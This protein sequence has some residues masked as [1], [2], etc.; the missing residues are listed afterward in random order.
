MK[1][2]VLFI[3]AILVISVFSGI[4]CCAAAPDSSYQLT[5]SDEFNGTELNMDLWHH[6]L[7]T[8][9]GGKNIAE[10]VRVSNGKL[11]LDYTKT[12]GI[13]S[14][15][16]IITNDFLPYGYYETKAKFFNGVKGLHTSFWTAGGALEID[17]FES[18]TSTSTGTPT[19]YYNLHYWW[20]EHINHGGGSYSVE[21]DG[22]SKTSDWFTMGFEWLPGKIN[23]YANGKFV[24][25]YSPDVYTPS[26]LWLT[27]VATPEWC[28]YKIDDSKMDANGYFGSS[29]YEYFRYYAKKLKGVNLLGNG[30]FELSRENP[31]AMVRY[32]GIS[33][34]A[35]CAK[36]PYAYDGYCYAHLRSGTSLGEVFKYLPSAKYTFEGYFK[37]PTGTNAT[38]SVKDAD[39][40]IIK[41]MTIPSNDNWTLVSLKDIEVSA[42]A[43][44]VI[45]V[46]SGHLSVDNL[47]FYCQEGDATYENYKEGDYKTYNALAD[48]ESKVINNSLI[49]NVGYD[50]YQF[51][52][53]PYYFG[54]LTPYVQGTETYIPYQPIKDKVN[55]SGVSSTAQ[56][57]SISQINATSD[58]R[59]L[60]DGMCILIYPSSYSAGS[61]TILEAQNSLN[62]FIDPSHYIYKDATYVGTADKSGQ[63]VYKFDTAVTT[64]TWGY[65][66]LGY[67]SDGKYTGDSTAT[68]TWSVNIPAPAKYSIQIYSNSH[69]GNGDASFTT[70]FAGVNVTTQGKV[71][72]YTINQYDGSV[73]W[74]DLGTYEFKQSGKVDIKLYN[75]SGE[76]LLRGSA[77]RIITE[78][79]RNAT[80][81][82]T[83]NIEKQ[84]VFDINTCTL[85]GSWGTSS[86]GYSGGSRYTGN[87]GDSAV[88]N[89]V[90]P[91][92][93]TYSV[94]IYNIAHQG[95][96]VS[97][98]APSTKQA[99]VSVKQDD[100]YYLYYLDQYD[101]NTGWYDLG[102]FN[103]EKG[104]VL[105]I[106]I[107]NMTDEGLLR[108]NAVRFIKSATIENRDAVYVGTSSKDNQKVFSVSNCTFT[109]SSWGT[110][111]LGY[112]SSSKYS[113]SND[114][115]ATWN[116][117]PDSDGIYSIQIYNIVH[118]GDKASGASPSTLI[119]GVDVSFDE[120]IYKYTLNQCEGQ[121]GWYDLGTFSLKA[122]STIPVKL[123]N[124]A[125]SGHLRACA[126]RLVPAKVPVG[127]LG[128][129]VFVGTASEAN[130][131]FYDLN[132]ATK[133]GSWLQSGGT[134]W[135]CYYGNGTAAT[136]TWTVSPKYNKK[137]SVQIYIPCISNSNTTEDAILNLKI[138]E[139][140]YEYHF[141]QRLDTTANSGWYDLGIFNLTTATQIT[142]K[143]SMT[144]GQFLRA[145][146]F[147]LVPVPDS[148]NVTKSGT[149]VSAQLGLLKNHIDKV[150][151]AEYSE[152]QLKNVQLVPAA[153]TVNYTMTNSSND[154]KVFYWN[155]INSMNPL[156]A[157][158][159]K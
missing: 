34:G 84:L 136:A 128:T 31:S 25:T 68:A 42:Y 88:W 120:T 30:H 10:N 17:G 36:S 146:A 99:G 112:G 64:G 40:K 58:Y 60:T 101:G 3:T 70:K 130:Q 53:S 16:G 57:V 159:I 114:A 20:G 108:A 104:E 103:L 135:D 144:S 149:S 54:N 39:G 98:A 94:Q 51:E 127:D 90:A 109:G 52:N 147:R 12:D 62:K 155:S 154:L 117:A 110:S 50:T 41:S 73:G 29:E 37:A 48:S 44:P 157:V 80:Y 33:K 148:I 107:H 95:D 100:N 119:A 137:Y 126:I 134:L 142:A 140:G 43:S 151:F 45:E 19:P 76:G 47:T 69:K 78:N 150:I 77:I 7:G 91:V 113:P 143:L 26:T 75:A 87:A 105:P 56:Y 93:G 27:A 24:G 116:I 92:T 85:K 123:Y 11:Y 49:A 13:Y 133:T 124:I 74:Y 121:M 59:A 96:K 86:L 141:N 71:N 115:V 139:K 97:N 67:L 9:Y 129:S 152:N 111:S 138:G 132:Y 79:L 38:L 145:K 1:K 15:A 21:T 156:T 125:Q 63:T 82:G 22:D 72:S 61:A 55:I 66:S 5:F 18:D 8:T 6:R 2:I 118:G 65:S 83:E 102:T 89:P 153:A 28:D 158:T 14:G 106:S 23:Y 81:I 4:I 32:F 131:E 35:L 122:S 46:T